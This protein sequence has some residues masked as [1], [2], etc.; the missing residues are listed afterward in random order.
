MAYTTINKSSDYFNTKLYTGNDSTNA[1]TGV[2][3]Q[4]DWVWAKARTS[5]TGSSHR[6]Y[7]SV[8]GVTKQLRIENANAEITDTE[9]TSFDSDGF[10]IDDDGNGSLNDNN[11]GYV[12]PTITTVKIKIKK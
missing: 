11:I 3:F 8:R 2:G 1:Q 6:L 9:L 12:V 4:P 10:T 7:D 5:T